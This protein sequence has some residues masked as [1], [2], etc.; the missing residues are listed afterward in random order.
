MQHTE[1]HKE[2][3]IRINDFTTIT[4]SDEMGGLGTFIDE[5]LRN[6]K[7]VFEAHEVLIDFLQHNLEYHKRRK[8]SILHAHKTPEEYTEGMRDFARQYGVYVEGEV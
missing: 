6:V 7:N 1:H 8:E 5:R 4:L 3:T 2:V